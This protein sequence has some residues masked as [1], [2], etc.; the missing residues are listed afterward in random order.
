MLPFFSSCI[1]S[2]SARIFLFNCCISFS[3]SFVSII[4]SSNN[5]ICFS[6]STSFFPKFAITPLIL[7]LLL[8]FNIIFSLM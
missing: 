7:E 4:F 5:L 6:I 3:S 8:S 1:L 2:I